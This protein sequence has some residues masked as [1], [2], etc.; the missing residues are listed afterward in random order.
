MTP[1]A[2]VALRQGVTVTAT[3]I[4]AADAARQS[5]A[6]SGGAQM[7]TG[8]Y[9]IMSNGHWNGSAAAAS[10]LGFRFILPQGIPAGVPFTSAKLRLRVIE[11]QAGAAPLQYASYFQSPPGGVPFSAAADLNSRNRSLGEGVHMVTPG[12]QGSIIEFELVRS[13]EILAQLNPLPAGTAVVIIL[14]ANPAG[15]QDAWAAVAGSPGASQAAAEFVIE[16][17]DPNAPVPPV[18]DF[19]VTPASLTGPAPLTVQAAEASTPGNS[20]IV[21]TAWLAGSTAYTTPDITHVFTAAGTY[22]LQLTVTDQNGQTSQKTVS[23]VVTQQTQEPPPPPDPVTGGLIKSLVWPELVGLNPGESLSRTYNGQAWELTLVSYVE[24]TRRQRADAVLRVTGP[25][26]ASVTKSVRVGRQQ[27]DIALGGMRV[28]PFIEQDAA[29]A[30]VGTGPENIEGAGQQGSLPLAT[31]MVKLL[32][33]DAREQM[34]PPGVWP[35][36]PFPWSGTHFQGFGETNGPEMHSGHD[37]ALPG[38][39]WYVAPYDGWVYPESAQATFVPE[40]PIN[41]SHTLFQEVL[42][43]NVTHI[44]GS[45]ATV[46]AGA[47]VTKGQ[48]LFRSNNVDRHFHVGSKGHRAGGS[49]LLDMA[50]WQDSGAPTWKSPRFWMVS[51]VAAGQADAV[52]P[53][54]TPLG[55]KV[56]DSFIN[57]PVPVGNMAITPEFVDPHT[58]PGVCHISTWAFSA[59]GGQASLKLGATRKAV[60]RINGSVRATLD[61]SAYF[62]SVDTAT[63]P[64]LI[65]DELEDLVTLQPGWNYVVITS[66]HASATSERQWAVTFKLEQPGLWFSTRLGAASV[67]GNINWTAMDHHNRAIDG[68][69]LEVSTLPSFATVTSYD[70]GLATTKSQ[71][72]L[73]LASGQLNYIRVVPY[74]NV[75]GAYLDMADVVQVQAGGQISVPPARVAPGGLSAT[76]VPQFV[77]FGSDDNNRAGAM[78]LFHDVTLDRTDAGGHPVR[79]TFYIIGTNIYGPN[80]DSQVWRNEYKRLYNAKHEIGNHGWWGNSPDHPHNTVQEWRD[81]IQTT[82]EKLVQMFTDPA[83]LGGPITVAEAEAALRGYRAAGDEYNANMHTVL[84]ELG[85]EYACSTHTGGPQNQPAYFPGTIE[86]GWPG[87]EPWDNHQV[88]NHP[89]Q[90]EIPQSYIE[91]SLTCDK[92]FFDPPNN[93]TGQYWKDAVLALLAKRYAGNRAPV[94]VCMHSQDWGPTDPG[95]SNYNSERID[96]FAELLDTI[97]AQ[98]P[99]VRIVTQAQ[100]LDWMKN[101]VTLAQFDAG[102]TP[103]PPPPP[104][105]SQPGIPAIAP[106]SFTGLQ[107]SLSVP[108]TDPDATDQWTATVD[109]GDGTP[110]ESAVVNAVAKTISDSHTYATAGTRTATVRVQDAGGLA[111]TQTVQVTTTA[112]TPPPGTADVL[113]NIS[114][115]NKIGEIPPNG[116]SGA[117]VE[118]N[119]QAGINP[120]PGDIPLLVQM[121]RMLRL[122]SIRFGWGN[123]AAT[124]GWTRSNVV[125]RG[126]PQ[127]G[128]IPWASVMVNDPVRA[129]GRIDRK[130]NYYHV[131]RPDLIDSLAKFRDEV[132]CDIIMQCNVLDRNPVS[133]TRD[134]GSIE[135]FPGG[136]WVDMFRY[137]KDK[138]IK[139]AEI[140]NELDYTKPWGHTG[141]AADH[142]AAADEYTARFI[143]EYYRPLKALDPTIKVIGPVTAHP[144][145]GNNTGYVWAT[146]F[147]MRCAEAG[148][149][150]DEHSLHYYANPGIATGVSSPDD[151]NSWSPAAIMAYNRFVGSRLYNGDT[152][153]PGALVP[154][155]HWDIIVK[156]WFADLWPAKLHELMIQYFGKII[157]ITVT[158]WR[159]LSAEGNEVVHAMPIMVPWMV[160][161]GMRLLKNGISNLEWYD[162]YETSLRAGMVGS[163]LVRTPIYGGLFLS[164]LHGH[165]LLDSTVDA[166][167]WGS[168]ATRDQRPGAGDV[169]WHM[170]VSPEAGDRD[171]QI[172]LNGLPQG[173][174]DRM[175]IWRFERDAGIGW[176]SDASGQQVSI[177]GYKVDV[178]ATAEV[179]L[180]RLYAAG[181]VTPVTS[182]NVIVPV[183]A[184][185][186]VAI[187]FS[188]APVTPPLPQPPVSHFGVTPSPAT[189]PAPFH[190][191][192]NANGSAPKAN[193]LGYELDWGDGTIEDVQDPVGKSHDY[194]TPNVY[195]ARF[196][197]Y[198][199]GGFSEWEEFP[200]T[201][202]GAPPPTPVPDLKWSVPDP[203]SPL[204]VR[205]DASGSQNATKFSIDPGDGTAPYDTPVAFHTYETGG[206]YT[207]SLDVSTTSVSVPPFSV[208]VSVQEPPGAV[209]G[210][211][212][213]QVSATDPFTWSFVYSG[214]GAAALVYDFADGSPPEQVGSIGDLVEH[215]FLDYG[216]Y[217]VEQRV[218]DTLGNERTPY[219]KTVKIELVPAEEGGGAGVGALVLTIVA[220]AIGISVA[221]TAGGR[222]QEPPATPPGGPI[223]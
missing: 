105:N 63:Q 87:N 37:V 188:N 174:V 220:G 104:T 184:Y 61:K 121:A 212:T 68:Y 138:G 19:D 48:Q 123:G 82:H 78:R 22:P 165:E 75:E 205:F 24:T 154:A 202:T 156:R 213:A 108:F 175:T 204:R 28:F 91:G 209:T 127:D 136:M 201:V 128:G 96:A 39:T 126:S 70:A 53:P 197:A 45:T 98:F 21:S 103:P 76:S 88:G 94:S 163:N 34:F 145:E 160:D 193:I 158:E 180:D 211:F 7:A 38:G 172:N 1:P 216:S 55:W 84:E 51:P 44:D 111:A 196:R 142:R 106:K 3:V 93:R 85:Y 25:G 151:D 159:Q 199:A 36:P 107:A 181:Q 124:Q 95:G 115:A 59:T 100:L 164:Q 187:A 185:D 131:Y 27:A 170:I 134:N 183:R 133:V 80:I 110:A 116:Q 146:Q 189:G 223:L 114:A 43:F 47:H 56:V 6:A 144:S 29:P 67:S 12:A 4:D 179:N 77:V 10:N 168:V 33:R 2:A 132:G 14:V 69:R 41:P 192:I 155:N 214:I 171:V 190:L 130:L 112:A 148:I 92:D 60:V 207:A 31:K 42:S 166:E 203:Q 153:T 219:R 49:P 50:L 57:G 125:D 32:I 64:A 210:G 178:N 90:W 8:P 182:P 143:D 139:Y 101:P 177:N 5:S 18:A 62:A 195:T 191:A 9:L 152:V 89:G 141:S 74:N 150:P 97:K 173:A 218:F 149:V 58:T 186:T 13:F 79:M 83:A 109:W 161:V 198:N 30:G 222:R 102:V 52:T 86:N 40:L 119:H 15:D 23:V 206:Q 113:V 140:G 217:L 157:P 20:P 71:A 66:D 99:E 135:T 11:G 26:G 16:Y 17:T 72:S 129:G 137:A 208:P 120:G 221:N 122:H 117:L 35:Y 54:S 169:Y 162:L 73:N 46:G 194:A 200:V 167:G 215:T 147:M 176:N 81:W 118:W 65:A